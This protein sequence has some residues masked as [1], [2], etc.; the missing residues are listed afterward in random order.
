[1]LA[2]TWYAA[3]RDL[4]SDRRNANKTNRRKWTPEDVITHQ[5]STVVRWHLQM[6]H[7]IDW[8]LEDRVVAIW[9]PE[10]EIC[11]CDT[12]WRMFQVP[13]GRIVSKASGMPL[14]RFN[15][16]QCQMSPCCRSDNKS[17]QHREPQENFFCTKPKFEHVLIL[18]HK[19]KN[20]RW[21]QVSWQDMSRFPW[22]LT[23][24]L[25]INKTSS[26][27]Q[28]HMVLKTFDT[29]ISPRQLDTHQ[30]ID[31]VICAVEASAERVFET[32]ANTSVYVCVSVW[33]LRATNLQHFVVRLKRRL[34]IRPCGCCVRILRFCYDKDTRA[35]PCSKTSWWHLYNAQD[36]TRRQLCWA[37]THNACL[38]S[39]CYL[40]LSC[41]TR[42]FS[43]PDAMRASHG[44]LWV[45]VHK[46]GPFAH[47]CAKLRRT[48]QAAEWQEKLQSSQVTDAWKSTQ[49]VSRET[50]SHNT[51]SVFQESGRSRTTWIQELGQCRSQAHIWGQLAERET[52][53][54]RV[55]CA[56]RQSIRSER[57]VNQR[58]E[59]VVVCQ[60]TSAASFVGQILSTLLLPSSSFDVTKLKE[61]K[62]D[63][64]YQS[65]QDETSSL[66][67]SYKGSK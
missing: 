36:H 56:F 60:Q 19:R 37:R 50:P 5:R 15:G 63:I 13:Q 16:T 49:T 11:C 45:T 44:K 3:K 53:R 8:T 25:R 57:Y 55:K 28:R 26:H 38:L 48:T 30:W 17:R 66:Y 62:S 46:N 65:H 61:V 32:E 24:W 59:S 35:V 33:R 42:G 34:E 67:P 29:R 64:D 51:A 21:R 54:E 27:R 31:Y 7:D 18:W 43:V 1:M 39:W 52:E 23:I 10:L 9:S 40:S 58:Y 14:P 12:S 20:S 2:H 41:E 47:D 22:R 6:R 4:P